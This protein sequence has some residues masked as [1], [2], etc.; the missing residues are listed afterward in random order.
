M[1]W[2][3]H[4]KK[5]LSSISNDLLLP[6]SQPN[7]CPFLRPCTLNTRVRCMWIVDIECRKAPKTT[8]TSLYGVICP[9]LIRIGLIYLSQMSLWFRR[10]QG[11]EHMLRCDQPDSGMEMIT[12]QT[13]GTLWDKL[14]TKRSNPERI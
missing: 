10:P 9:P 6:M 12:C 5:N 14:S 13:L 4:W 1:E 8:E 7:F 2:T 3:K 11:P